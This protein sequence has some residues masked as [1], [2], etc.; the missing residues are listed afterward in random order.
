M[1]FD[2]THQSIDPTLISRIPWEVPVPKLVAVPQAVRVKLIPAIQK[3]YHASGDSPV[4]PSFNKRATY[5][6]V[7]LM[8][9]MYFTFNEGL[10]DHVFRL[11]Q[12]FTPPL[13]LFLFFRVLYTVFNIDL[14]R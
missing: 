6:F 12:Y 14:L 11:L 4:M 8:R 10:L 5:S 3:R 1:T 7:L 13:L 2:P 9:F